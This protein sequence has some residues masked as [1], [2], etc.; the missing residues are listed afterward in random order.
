MKTQIIKN[1]IGAEFSLTKT[2]L[3]QSRRQAFACVDGVY[4]Y[5]LLAE[6]KE[7]LRK[8]PQYLTVLVHYPSDT[9]SPITSR[10]RIRK[11]F[12]R[13]GCQLFRGVNAAAI[14]ARL[15]RAGQCLTK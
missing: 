3:Q 11:S 7:E 8:N 6:I 1:T 13:I 12:V 2:R 9:F 15:G 10:V 14:K 4:R 5:V